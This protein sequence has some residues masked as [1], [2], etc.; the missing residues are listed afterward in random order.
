MSAQLV[1]AIALAVAFAFTNGVHDASNAIAPLV[2]TRAA[3]PRGAIRLAA[4]CNLLGPL[5]L[6]TA[7]ADTVAGIVTVQ[8]SAGVAI[9]GAAL[10]AA[11]A[12]NAATWALG[13]PSSSGHALVGGLVGAGLAGGGVDAIRWGGM[14]GW[15]PV[16][17]LG[18]LVG[19]AVSPLLG[20]AAALLAVRGLR[21]GG[22]RATRRW[23][24]PARGAQ[25]AMSAA[26]AM[27]H[28][29]NDAQKSVGVIA[30]VLLAAGRVDTISAPP[31]ATATC[32]LALTAGTAVG[33]W[34]I[35]KTVGRRIFRI[36]PV[37]AVASQA[38]SSGV[39]LGA[40]L[41]GAPVSTTQIVASSVLGV[42]G[43]RRR[44]RHVNWLIVRRMALGW[45]VTLP[46][47]A[48]LAAVAA[49]VWRPI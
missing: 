1:V 37:D 35:V 27:S 22:R 10:L 36:H 29:A 28:G 21:A 49:L 38:A 12:W 34:R 14:D 26:L 32:A 24:A 16:G 5:L 2:A 23:R 30:A 3:H 48:A 19:L 40:S 8:G 20:G 44:W 42:G 9:A 15:H 43:G 45:I 4:A 41:I 47:S 13:L 31:W 17:V 46:A 7:V 39:I 18:T 11:V 33:G 25:W 6:G